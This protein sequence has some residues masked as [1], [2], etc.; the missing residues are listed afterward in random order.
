[1]LGSS[2]PPS[3]PLFMDLYFDTSSL[4]VV[5]LPVEPL[6]DFGTSIVLMGILSVVAVNSQISAYVACQ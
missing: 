2:D 1:M 6:P 4:P 5:R 3:T